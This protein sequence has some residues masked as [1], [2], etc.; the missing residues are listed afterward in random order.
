MPTDG[1]CK[2]CPGYMKASDDG[3]EC[4]QQKCDNKIEILTFE[5]FCK[6][7]PDYMRPEKNGK[8]CSMRTCKPNQRLKKDGTCHDC[9]PYT[10]VTADKT[11]CEPD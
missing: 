9:E 3:L 11:N 7:C 8:V 4:I 5:G 10:R 1:R 2:D 6:T